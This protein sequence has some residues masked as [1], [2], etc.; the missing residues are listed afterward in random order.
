MPGHDIIVLGA[1]AGGVEAL[2][3]VVADL[4]GDLPAS[5]FIVLHIP[6]MASALPQILGRRS[7]LPVAH[8]I[9]G[10]P[11]EPGRV[12]VAPP[13][14]H[15]LLQSGQVRVVPG[16]KENGHRPAVDPLFRTA[17]LAYGSRVV[18]VILSGSLDDGTAGLRAVK[19]RGGMAVVQDP[20]EALYR[21]M[22]MHA[23]EGDHPDLILPLAEIGKALA[24]LAESSPDRQE[25][26]GDAMPDELE[27]ELEWTHPDLESRETNPPLGRP[28]GFT[29]PECHGALWELHDG[30]LVRFRCRVGHGFSSGS[31]VAVQSDDV[32][33]A[34]WTAFRALEERAALCRKLAGRA[35]ERQHRHSAGHFE[36]QAAHAEHRA[37]S[38]GGLLHPAGSAPETSDLEEDADPDPEALPRE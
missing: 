4:P 38:L 29:C 16:P 8:A 19:S 13:D 25:Q 33:A 14:R 31:L 37:Q 24:D 21:G 20:E 36:R 10:E 32:E 34:L 6:P 17:A 3:R 1:S 7:K 12:Y 2:S 35:T 22:P 27:A 5:V 18:A 28:S 23:V 11:I 26:G 30:E 15:L 9:D